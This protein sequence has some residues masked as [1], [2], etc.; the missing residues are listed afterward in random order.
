MRA[1]ISVVLLVVLAF[2]ALIQFS[3]LASVPSDIA[4]VFLKALTLSSL[5]AIV[6]LSVLWFL[7][8]REREGIWLFAAA[9]L[10]GGL[11]ATTIALPF[12]N[13]SFRLVDAWV[14][15]NPAVTQTLG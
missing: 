9:F 15:E 10:W 13:A 7:D 6:P 8:R 11:V 14:A 12:N 5:L 3:A 2:A 1:V 4:G